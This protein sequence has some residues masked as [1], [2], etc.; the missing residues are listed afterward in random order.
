MKR[1]FVLLA[2]LSLAAPIA[3]AERLIAFT[4]ATV[5]PIAGPS[6][7]DG[8]VVVRGKT[9]EAVGRAEEVRV[10]AGAER[11]DLAGRVL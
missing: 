4:G 7:D 3:A 6:I 5:I 2:A 1:S 8:V 11:I 9:I 10:P